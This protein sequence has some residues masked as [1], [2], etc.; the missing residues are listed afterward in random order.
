MAG[1]NDSQ[2]KKED[3]YVETDVNKLKGWKKI[4]NQQIAH[5]LITPTFKC[6]MICYSIMFIILVLF[7]G[8]SYMKAESNNDLLYRYDDACSGLDECSVNITPK[9]TLKK[10]K[11]Y[12]RLD[13]FYSNHR[14][15]V[16]SRSYGQLRGEKM[17]K[18]D[19][20]EDCDP[21][22]TMGDL[23]QTSVVDPT[24]TLSE[25]DVASPCGLIGMFI[26][27]DTY[28]LAQ[29][30]VSIPID[31]TNIAHD[32]DKDSKFK[33]GNNWE[34]KQYRDIEDEHLMVWYQMETFPSFI[35][36][37]GHIDQDLE[38]G[39]T[40]TF[41]IQNNFE[42]SYYD[43]KKYIYLSEVND[44][45]GANNFMGMVFLIIAGLVALIMIVF[46]VL[47]ITR[48]HNNKDIYSTDKMEW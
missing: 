28:T 35:K 25:K 17:G 37:W 21:V 16:K 33:N 24:V 11:F 40:Y 47:Y 3:E 4:K 46:V 20:N 10:P 18:S 44:F 23:G 6:A 12:Y 14:N 41:T 38:K 43:A 2:K 34:Q 45:G 30:D 39:Q 36:L 22:V 13:N 26:F 1:P 8:V 15:F 5:I 27:D 42:V 29:G 48:L 32:V 31:D 9:V 7:G 19:V